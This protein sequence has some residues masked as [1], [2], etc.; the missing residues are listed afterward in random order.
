M[1]RVLT[2]INFP[3]DWTQE[4]VEKVDNNF[5][6]KYP[7]G[8]NGSGLNDKKSWR[9]Q[10]LLDLA[11]HKLTYADRDYRIGRYPLSVPTDQGQ[12]LIKAIE[13]ELKQVYKQVKVRLVPSN[14]ANTMDLSAEPWN[15][16]ASSLGTNGIFCQLGK[17]IFI[18]KIS[19]LIEL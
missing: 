18:F 13:N 4:T 17:E 14:E 5:R 2:D 12:A 7:V 6:A 16:A 10:R 9:D 3:S 19:T 1:Q 8:E 15:L 11:K